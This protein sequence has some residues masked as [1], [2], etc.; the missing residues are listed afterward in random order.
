MPRNVAIVAQAGPVLPSPKPAQPR[1]RQSLR[2]VEIGA[3]SHSV[4]VAVVME[5]DVIATAAD[6]LAELS[7]AAA[8]DTPAHSHI[9]PRLERLEREFGLEFGVPNTG[10]KADVK[11]VPKVKKQVAGVVCASD[12]SA[13]FRS[14]GRRR[15][16]P[17]RSR[18]A[19]HTARRNN[20]TS[21][22][23]FCPIDAF[24]KS[25]EDEFASGRSNGWSVRYGTCHIIHRFR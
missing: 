9:D 19:T 14:T 3:A 10:N 20:S 16:A 21:K 13:S 2:S 15:I 7:D 12:R 4:N 23:T 6:R 22:S 5:R 17:S 11:G 8:L 25:L 18:Y 1:R 24:L